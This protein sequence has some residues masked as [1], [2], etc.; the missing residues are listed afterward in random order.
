MNKKWLAVGYGSGNACEILPLTINENWQHHLQSNLASSLA[1]SNTL[2]QTDYEALH[3]N[4][5]DRNYHQPTNGFIIDRVG[6]TK[7]ETFEDQDIAFYK[8]LGN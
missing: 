3:K 4:T 5:I 2:S 1:S 7:N 8:F 6:Q